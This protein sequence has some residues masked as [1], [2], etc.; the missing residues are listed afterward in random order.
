MFMSFGL[1]GNSMR[2][3]NI[4]GPVVSPQKGR[5]IYRHRLNETSSVTDSIF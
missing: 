5:T 3:R 4:M 2:Q 1:D